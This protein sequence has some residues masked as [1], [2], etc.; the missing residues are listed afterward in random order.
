MSTLLTNPPGWAL[1][2]LTVLSLPQATA[3]STYAVS[4]EE[5]QAIALENL[6]HIAG[7]ATAIFATIST[8][9]GM[10][11]ASIIGLN[12]NMTLFPIIF[13]YLGAGVFAYLLM[14]WVAP[15]AKLGAE[16]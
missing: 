13:G 15:S 14:V 8:L 2:F 7:L 6:G 3:Q 12:F 11:V 9:S 4:L 5:A 10:A 1:V 16:V